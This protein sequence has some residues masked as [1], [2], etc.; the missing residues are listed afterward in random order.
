M[1][2]HGDFVAAGQSH[3]GII[4]SEQVRVGELV[5]RLQRFLN[6][7]HRDELRNNLWWLTKAG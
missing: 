2:L 6:T 4:V 3:W 1:R 5:R 7:Y